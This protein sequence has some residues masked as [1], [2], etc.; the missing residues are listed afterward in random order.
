MP[1]LRP[2]LGDIVIVEG[3]SLPG[4]LVKSILGVPELGRMGLVP[5]YC[6]KP[7]CTWRAE[8]ERGLRWADQQS[9]LE[10]GE[11][12][13]MTASVYPEA[14]VTCQGFFPPWATEEK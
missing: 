8:E 12:G 3:Q 6:F 5:C 10:A 9:I 13:G 14:L 7:E 4:S 11:Q 2:G 1:G